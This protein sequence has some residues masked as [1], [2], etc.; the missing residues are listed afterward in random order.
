MR[1][2]DEHSGEHTR[3]KKGSEEDGSQAQLSLYLKDRIDRTA[4]KPPSKASERAAEL[5][6][7]GQPDLDS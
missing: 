7:K 5:D 2:D 1:A 3:R 6:R 4:L